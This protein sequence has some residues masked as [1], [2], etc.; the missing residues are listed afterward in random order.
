MQNTY[1]GKVF[2]TDVGRFL[3]YNLRGD[4]Q[5]FNSVEAANIFSRQ[6][7]PLVHHLGFDI[8]PG[9]VRIFRNG[10]QVFTAPWQLCDT[11]EAA[12][13]LIERSVSAKTVKLKTYIPVELDNYELFQIEN[14]GNILK[15]LSVNPDGDCDNSEDELRRAAHFQNMQYDRQ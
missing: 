8:V 1:S 11:M 6:G 14:Y 9:I 3:S 7:G 2:P 4:H 10:V 15:P 13:E 12:K 5:N